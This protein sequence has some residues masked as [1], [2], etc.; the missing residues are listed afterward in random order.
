MN[1]SISLGRIAGVRVGLNWSV[2][3]LAGLLMWTLATAVFP[4]SDPGLGAGAHASVLF[5]ASILLHELGHAVQARRDGME[6]DGITLWAFG[7]V[8]RFMG[9]FPGA[10]AEFR[11]AIAGPLVSLALAGGFLG[12]AF[13]PGLPGS[14]ESVAAWLGYTNLLLLVFNMLPALPLDGGRVFRAAVWRGT[15]D[16]L[17]ATRVAS[18]LGGGFAWL[19]IL[20]GVALTVLT[21]T[22]S[23]LWLAFI[24]LFLQQAAAG[25]LRA[26]RA[27]RGME[28]LRVRDVMIGHPVTLDPD[29]PLETVAARVAR[30]GAVTGYPVVRAG[31]VYGMLA[32]AVIARVPRAAWATTRVRDVMVPV[33]R[34]ALVRE[35]EPV[36][37]VLERLQG[38]AI[39]RALVVDDH[40]SL[41][42]LLS[43]TDVAAALRG[44]PNAPR[45]AP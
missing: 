42:G 29:T 45:T 10:G 19:L 2:V 24:G 12:L 6:I 27:V 43:V 44:G 34:V 37:D 33:D 23:G 11:I 15:G 4:D 41:V 17:K 16:F 26:A 7:G 21:G 31:Q 13:A 8:A 3:V 36:R 9:M 1:D 14:V 39:P 5:A 20:G 32:S 30:Y 25:E 18:A 40:R 22:F 35:D 38:F 28:A